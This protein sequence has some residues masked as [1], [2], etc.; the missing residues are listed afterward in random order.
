MIQVSMLE[1]KSGQRCVLLF[2]RNISRLCIPKDITVPRFHLPCI[3]NYC[4]NTRFFTVVKSLETSKLCVFK[5]TTEER[6]W[7]E[8]LPREDVYPCPDHS[9]QKQYVKSWGLEKHLA[10]GVH[11]YKQDDTGVN[12]GIKIW[13]EMC[14]SVQQKYFKIVYSWSHNCSQTPFSIS[15][16][17]A[18]KATVKNTRFSP[19]VKEYIHKIFDLWKVWKT[20]KLC[21]FK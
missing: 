17:W 14:S 3:E 2:S 21:D 18:L 16:G 19:R 4:K 11:Q 13:A 5:W 12:A 9:G 7:Y 15:Q 8:Q 6:M 10:M 20:S 1:L